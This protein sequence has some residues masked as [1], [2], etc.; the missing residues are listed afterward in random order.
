MLPSY[1]S[2]SDEGSWER[3]TKLVIALHAV[4]TAPNKVVSSCNSGLS[5]ATSVMN[6]FKVTPVVSQT[7]SKTGA[8]DLVATFNALGRRKAGPAEKAE[9]FANK[10]MEMAK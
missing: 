4:S 10:K 3:L 5:S 2:V 7:S 8:F 1:P 9:T 6:R